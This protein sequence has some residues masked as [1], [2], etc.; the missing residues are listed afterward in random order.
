M[1]ANQTLTT[2]RT[3]TLDVRGIRTLLRES[4]PAS[5][6]EAVVFVHGNPGPA[7]DWDDLVDAGGAFARCLA[8]D[9]PGFGVSQVGLPFGPTV[10]G[11]ADHLGATLDHLGVERAHLVLHDFGGPWGLTWAAAN[12]DRFAS[13]VL[14]NTGVLPGYKWHRFARMWRTPVL[15]EVFMA[16]TTRAGLRWALRMGTP[17]PPPDDAIDRLYEAYTPAAKRTVLAL[18]R[19]EPDPSGTSSELAEVLRPLDRPALAIFGRHDPYIPTVLAERQCDAFPSARIE[20]LE[21]SGH[22]PMH[23]DPSSLAALVVPFLGSVVCR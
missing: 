8:W 4:G 15:G 3:R 20:I 23:D 14:I 16:T 21:G 10:A 13:A 18:Y 7:D 22:W 1:S 9:H 2:R 12:P 6:A 11:Y 5:S 17:V 19:S